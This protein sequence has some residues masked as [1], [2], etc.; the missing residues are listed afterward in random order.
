M[1]AYGPCVERFN[2]FDYIVWKI[3][4]TTLSFSKSFLVCVKTGLAVRAL[5]EMKKIH[6]SDWQLE[7]IQLNRI[8]KITF[9]TGQTALF[10]WNSR[11]LKS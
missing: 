3:V 11:V 2:D 5:L 1:A 4:K 6:L 9:H 10:N 7:F 8:L